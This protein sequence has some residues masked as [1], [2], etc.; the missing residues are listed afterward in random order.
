MEHIP[1][2]KPNNSRKYRLSYKYN[3]NM[4]IIL[5]VNSGGKH[6]YIVIRLYQIPTV[7]QAIS[8]YISVINNYIT[9]CGAA[10]IIDL[11]VCFYAIIGLELADNWFTFLLIVFISIHGCVITFGKQCIT[12]NHS[13]SDNHNVVLT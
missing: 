4:Y 6:S 12:I 2:N 5:N 10:Y 8:N 3:S 9:Y 1:T 7:R 11:T 13:M